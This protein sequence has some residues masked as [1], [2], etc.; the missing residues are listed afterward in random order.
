MGFL[1][2]RSIVRNLI[3][4][5]TAVHTDN[6][7]VPVKFFILVRTSI[8]PESGNPAG[9]LNDR[10]STSFL[11]QSG[12]NFRQAR[13]TFRIRLFVGRSLIEPRASVVHFALSFSV[14][15][16]ITDRTAASRYSRL[17]ARPWRALITSDRSLRGEK[18]QQLVVVGRV[19][20]RS[21]D[22]PSRFAFRPHF[23]RSLLRLSR[24]LLISPLVPACFMP[25]DPPKP[26]QQWD[27]L[28]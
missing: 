15:R 4:L 5:T 1:I 16:K 18:Q 23:R 3:E 13:T 6:C 24:P 8:H 22:F 25:T 2:T 26:D 21:R 28:P 7:H 12:T 10:S 20:E 17:P 14:L 27:T 19:A 11:A 9:S